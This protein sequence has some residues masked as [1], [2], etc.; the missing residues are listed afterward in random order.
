MTD[1]VH[2]LL[3][4]CKNDLFHNV[5]VK[6]LCEKKSPSSNYF[7]SC[8]CLCASDSMMQE[9]LTQSETKLFSYRLQFYNLSSIRHLLQKAAEQSQYILSN[10]GYKLRSYKNALKSLIHLT[11]EVELSVK[12]ESNII[13]G[14][15]YTSK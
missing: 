9:F 1:K 15:N 13:K 14:K 12:N 6:A 7:L 3:N 10:E 8:R 5:N 4:L 11:E 2:V